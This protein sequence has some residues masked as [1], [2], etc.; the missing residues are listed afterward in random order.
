MVSS[1]EHNAEGWGVGCQMERSVVARLRTKW[2]VV[3][4]GLNCCVVKISKSCR[5]RDGTENVKMTT[6]SKADCLQVVS[7]T[8]VCK[9]RCCCRNCSLF[10]HNF[11][12]VGLVA[13]EAVINLFK[14]IEMF[15]K[16]VNTDK[17]QG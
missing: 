2:C 12:V 17:F 13:P 9:R 5:V 16:N 3:D 6:R 14:I 8:P 7:V 4:V 15:N 11:E 1:N 10:D